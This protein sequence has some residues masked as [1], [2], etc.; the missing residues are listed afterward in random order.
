[1]CIA[2]IFS[3][4]LNQFNSKAASVDFM[5]QFCFFS[6]RLLKYMSGILKYKKFVF[7]FVEKA[8]RVEFKSLFY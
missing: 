5:A 8:L 4:Y 3:L 1:M 7:I 6:L 2:R